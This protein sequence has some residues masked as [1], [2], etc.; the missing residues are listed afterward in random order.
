MELRT[1]EINKSQKFHAKWLYCFLV[2]VQH[3]YDRR[4]DNDTP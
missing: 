1:K 4:T 2:V 3:V